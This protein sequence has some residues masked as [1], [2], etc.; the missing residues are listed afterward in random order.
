MLIATEAKCHLGPEC[1]QLL[2]D[3]ALRL[4]QLLELIAEDKRKGWPAL[5]SDGTGTFISLTT[6]GS[7]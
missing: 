1:E 6:C 4:S 2:C 3:I 7:I 5:L